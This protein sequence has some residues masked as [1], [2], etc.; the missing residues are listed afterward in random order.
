MATRCAALHLRG[1]ATRIFLAS[2]GAAQ[3]SATPAAHAQADPPRSQQR[4]DSRPSAPV[5]SGTPAVRELFR[6]HCVECHGGDGAGKRARRRLPEIPDFTDPSWQSRRDDAQLL[7]SILDGKGD[8]MPPNRDEIDEEQARALVAYVRA[9]APTAGT[10]GRQDQEGP[11]QDE[12]EGV[13]PARPLFRKLVRWLGKFHPAAV[14]FPIALLT[15]AAL[16]ELLRIVTGKPAFDAISRF[17]VWFGALTAILAGT[18]GWF[19]AGFRPTDASWVMMTHRWLGT[20]TVV[21]AV[22]VLLL[23]ELSR[24]PERPRTRMGFRVILFVGAALVSAT[25]FFG[26]A[27]VFGIDHYT[28]PR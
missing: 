10:L 17:C 7:A 21:C 6:Q 1:L 25:G 9:F 11:A 5:A 3:L 23:S 4:P 26:G 27:L 2:L 12:Q 22:L 15:A 20:S 16:A 24:R 28:W 14:H 19:L 13:V 8:E 18:L